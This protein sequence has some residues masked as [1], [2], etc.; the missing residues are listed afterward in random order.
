MII[1]KTGLKGLYDFKLESTPDLTQRGGPGP[2]LTG[3]EPPPPNP[4]GPSIFTAIQDQLEPKLD[5]SKGPIEVLV[6]D[7]VQKPVE[8]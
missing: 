2:F 4:T 1:D 5:S 6:I 8:N 7:S 3:A